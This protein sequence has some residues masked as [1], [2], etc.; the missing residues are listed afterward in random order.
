MIY[1]S[2]KEAKGAATFT[3]KTAADSGIYIEHGP[4]IMNVLLEKQ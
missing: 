4:D 3:E 2:R 1:D